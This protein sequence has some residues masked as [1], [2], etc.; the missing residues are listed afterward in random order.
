MVSG[1]AISLIAKLNGRERT[2]RTPDQRNSGNL[3]EELEEK[4]G[5]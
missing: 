2:R 1:L 5:N 3:M 4:N